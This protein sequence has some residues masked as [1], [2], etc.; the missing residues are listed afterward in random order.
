MPQLQPTN[1]GPAK[2]QS[3]CIYCG[4]LNHGKGCRYAPHGVH[5][6][7]DDPTR[8]SYCGSK[9][10]G[11]GCHVN[12]ISD[13][14]VHGINYNTMFKE[15]IQSLL[16]MS[17]LLNELKK[18]YKQFPAYKLGLIDEKG[19]NIKKPVTLNE[20]TA[21]TPVVKNVLRLKRYLGPKVDLLEASI[22]LG[23]EVTDTTDMVRYKKFLEYKDRVQGVINELYKVLDEACQDGLSLE[24][25]TKLIKA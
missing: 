16:D 3:R 18:D 21:Y 6:H 2:Q 22:A 12:P 23:K 1:K 20:Q 17:F 9:N 7:P 14:H 4:S 10:Y 11:K 15:E 25:T 19:N 13:V 5:F 8:C 24:E